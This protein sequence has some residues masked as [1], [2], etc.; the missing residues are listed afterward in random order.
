MAQQGERPAVTKA[1]TFIGE[2]TQLRPNDGFRRP[3]R[4]IPDHLAIGVDN[5]AGPPFEEAQFRLLMRDA[6]RFAAGPT[7]S[8]P[9]A[10]EGPRHPSS[11]PPKGSSAWRL[12]P[13]AASAAGLGNVVPTSVP[14]KTLTPSGGTLQNKS[15]SKRTVCASIGL[16]QQGLLRQRDTQH[17]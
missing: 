4:S 15:L 16:T 12:H 17:P 11:A 13:R 7:V 9:E 5:G 6:S 8:L 3:A 14:R 2:L 1:L 10:R